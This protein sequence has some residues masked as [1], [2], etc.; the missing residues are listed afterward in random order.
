MGKVAEKCP[1][2]RGNRRQRLHACLSP[3]GWG[4][5]SK[6]ILRFMLDSSSTLSHQRTRGRALIG[7]GSNGVKDLHQSGAGKIMLPHVEGPPEVVFLNTSGGITGGDVLEFELRLTDGSATA[8]TQTA[9]RAY[10]STTGMGH[11][12]THLEVASGAHLNWL[13]QE[14]ILFEGSMLRRD[15]HVNLEADARLL[16]AEMLV[17]GRAAMGET[18]E[19]LHLKDRREVRRDGRLIYREALELTPEMLARRSSPALCG[20]ARA[21]GSLVMIAPDADRWLSALR[22]MHIEGVQ[23]ACSAWSEKLVVRFM[24]ADAFPLRQAMSAAIQ[25]LNLCQIPR[26]WQI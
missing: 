15:L 19:S 11:I 10:K 14:T 16:F 6:G 5:N 26:V 12:Q 3:L 21:I 23:M 20:D 24:A 8:T 17:L 2:L 22:E 25:T 4:S 7:L 1:V 9:E 18:I 13:P